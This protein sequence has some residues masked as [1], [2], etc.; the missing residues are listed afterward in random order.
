MFARC[1]QRVFSGCTARNRSFI[2]YVVNFRAFS[3]QSIDLVIPG[4]SMRATV[5]NFNQVLS[6]F[7][8]L[9]DKECFLNSFQKM[10]EF[11]VQPDVRTFNIILEF[12]L[13]SKDRDGFSFWYQQ[14]QDAKVPPNSETINHLLSF[15]TESFDSESIDHVLNLAQEMTNFQTVEIMTKYFAQSN[16]GD[17]MI[18]WTDASQPI[19]QKLSLNAVQHS[20]DLKLLSRK[21]IN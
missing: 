20:L 3:T 5:G 13:L 4:T 2:R 21:C 18:E 1:T 6:T 16:R 11:D 8:Q 15:Y 14:M 19:H 17:K 12:Y 7:S 9:Q 10:L